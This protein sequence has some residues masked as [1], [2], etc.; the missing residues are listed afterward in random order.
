MR[1]ELN[2]WAELSRNERRAL[3]QVFAGGS[4]RSASE[5]T[6]TAL[7][8]LDLI[9]GEHELTFRGLHTLQAVARSDPQR[10]MAA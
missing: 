1:I 10:R 5:S 3:L 9:S 2:T 6:I 4:L 7:H 8:R